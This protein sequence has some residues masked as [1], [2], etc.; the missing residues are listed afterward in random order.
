LLSAQTAGAAGAGATGFVVGDG[1]FEEHARTR[2]R[3][4]RI[5]R[6]I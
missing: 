6:I 2:T 5:T 4:E 1:D 3:S